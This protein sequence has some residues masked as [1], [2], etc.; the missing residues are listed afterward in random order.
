MSDT[1]PATGQVLEQ[2]WFLREGETGLHTF[3]RI[4]YYNETTPFLRNLQEF[5]TMF[6]PNSPIY[7][8][9]LTN[10]KQYAPL[11][12]D[13][14]ESKWIVVQDAT[15]Y[16]GNSPDDAYVQQE[17]DYFTKYTF[18]DTWRDHD[19]HGMFADGSNTPDNSTYGAWLVMNTKD[20]YFGGPLH[21]DLIVDGIVYNYIVSNH[22]GDQTP[23]ITNGMDRTFGPQYFH[24]NHFPAGSDIHTLKADA[25]QYADPTWNADFYDSIAQYVPNYVP[26]SQRTTWK[27]H[28]DLP[29]GAKNPIAVLAQ[30]GI[31]FQDNVFDTK[32][33]QYWANIA[34]D[35]TAEIP[36]VK[37][38]TYRLTIYA[39]GIFGQYIKD[40]VEVIAGEVHTTHAR[41]REE[42][43]GTEI[44][45]I[46]TPDKSSGEY[47]HGY[48][49]DP[50]HPL[51]PEEYR[52]YWAVYDYPTDFPEGVRF[53]VGESKES[54]DLNY[55]HWSV[56]GG[57]ANYLRPEPYYG[58]G[59]VNNWTIAFDLTDDQIHRKRLATFTVQFA[60]VKTA[61]GNT[62]VYNASE[63]HA[64]LKYT[65][66][67]NGK[68]LEPWVIP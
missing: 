29:E 47:K 15:W 63:P 55:V 27:L 2:Y 40:D 46:G 14:A 20:T 53:K 24:F 38:D 16:L 18:Q 11:P 43:A 28:V 44:F 1:Y 48:E 17:A 62:D 19:A 5:R 36:M 50:T 8:H 54:E 6:R 12:S 64:N 39:D 26:S 51:H 58:H 37:A 42:T 3:S 61:A 56:F 60:G 49:L 34:D 25:A 45:R 9:L 66:N 59:D 21:S 13:A 33:L 30:N 68:D 32:A 10:D 4:A 52:I 7:T 57:Y 67:V 41:W 31:D 22:H 23:N 65:V 35:G